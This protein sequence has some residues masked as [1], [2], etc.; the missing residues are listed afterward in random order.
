MRSMASASSF[1]NRCQQIIRQRSFWILLAM[2]AGIGALHYLT[3]QVRFLALLPFPLQRHTVERIIFLVP[4]AGATFAFGQTGGLVALGA[5]ILIMLPRIFLVFPQPA[6]ALVE[7]AAVAIVGYVIVWLIE[8]Q[9]REKRLRQRAVSRLRA[10][11]EVAA[12]VTE[13]LELDQVLNRALDKVL[14]VTGLDAGLAFLLDRPA[15]ELILTAYRGISEEAAAGV[16][17][18]RLGEGFCGRVAQSGEPMVVTDSSQD[19]RLTRMVVR[20]EGLRGQ[21][22]VPLK[23]KGEVQGV[24]AVASRAERSFLPD[25]LELIT[26]IGNEIGVAIENARLYESM[27]FYVRQ[28]TQAQEEERKRIAR[29][30]HDDT[31]QALVVLSRRLDA[32]AA[33]CGPASLP[34]DAAQRIAELQEL[35]DDVIRNVR[36]F[37]RDLRPSILDDLGL[38]PTLESLANELTERDG[39]PTDLQVRGESRRLP[40]ETEL[41]LFR[42]AQEALNNVRR[43][44]Q[45]RHASV[46][47]TFTDNTVQITVQDDGRGFVPP[48]HSGDLAAAGKLG[49][50]GMHER[51]RLLRG[52]LD[53]HSRPGQGT[54]VTV[55]VPA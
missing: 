26:A 18:L 55:T 14:E 37:S 30:L 50:M 16:D 22:I 33:A 49:L 4:V 3:P 42:I 1:R 27:R 25:E 54:C 36:R 11:N 28:I 29:E 19:P 39:I 15:Q 2:L 51:A 20:Q 31:V 9:E 17:R 47:V 53:V 5:A 41:T 8:T 52:T 12:I 38:L 35:M 32:L 13:S 21:V 23:S 44:A 10:I 7:T 34:Q 48:A 46:T 43:H 6:D 45:A 24:M 40:P